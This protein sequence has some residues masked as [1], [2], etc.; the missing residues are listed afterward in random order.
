[1]GFVSRREV[2]LQAEASSSEGRYVVDC[3]FCGARLR[4]P[5]GEDLRHNLL[6]AQLS[7]AWLI[8]GGKP[9]GHGLQLL[10]RKLTAFAY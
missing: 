6:S 5:Q 8:P 1:M 10:V 7:L 3:P 4:V 9:A 2:A